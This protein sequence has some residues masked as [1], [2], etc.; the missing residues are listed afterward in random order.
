MN[1]WLVYPMTYADADF[2]L[3]AFNARDFNLNYLY[4]AYD[5]SQ[6]LYKPDAPTEAFQINPFLH[7][8]GS[9]G[10]P[11]RC[12]NMSPDTPTISQIE[13]TGL[14]ARAIIRDRKS[15]RLNSSHQLIS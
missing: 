15:T 10:Y 1:R 8:G 7:R 13:I 11:G 3:I 4:V 12:N 9:C 2:D 6:N 14:P 5:Q